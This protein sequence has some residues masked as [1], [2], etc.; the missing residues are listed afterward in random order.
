MFLDWTK[1]KAFAENE[2]NVA[3]IMI[4]FFNRAENMVEKKRIFWLPVFSPFPTMFSEGS[5]FRV[6]KTRDCVVK[7]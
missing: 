3:E 2:F 6:D 1:F 5:Y 7:G 4:T